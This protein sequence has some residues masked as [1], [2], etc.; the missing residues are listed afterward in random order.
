MN[1]W[2][3]KLKLKH[4]NVYEGTYNFIY[5][6][7]MC[8][9][10]SSREYFSFITS[11]CVCFFGII[12]LF[13]SDGSN[14]LLRLMYTIMILNGIVSCGYHWNM[15]IWWKNMDELFIFYTACLCAFLFIDEIMCRIFLINRTLVWEKYSGKTYQTLSGATILAISLYVLISTVLV[16]DNN[17]DSDSL[18]RNDS[19]SYNNLLFPVLFGIP[20]ISILISIII[21]R[22]K[23]H[24]P[25]QCNK[26]ESIPH[27]D[28]IWHMYRLGFLG[29]SMCIFFVTIDQVIE[30]YCPTISWLR[31]LGVHGLYHIGMSDGFYIITQFFVFISADNEKYMGHIKYYDTKINP[32][33]RLLETIVPIVNYVERIH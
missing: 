5:E 15:T 16:I 30:S 21:M 31:Y 33:N 3:K 6:V 11:P 20:L 14:Q 29:A 18:S 26:Y 13:V 10:I 12:G 2:G 27:S 32:L 28:E 17:I 9:G 23:T 7:S 4:H 24:I 8:E 22:S 1:Y 19:L 25:I